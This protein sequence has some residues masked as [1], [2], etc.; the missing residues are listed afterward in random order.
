VPPGQHWCR[1]GFDQWACYDHHV[2]VAALG[3]A[4]G[5]RGSYNYRCPVP[6]HADH[7]KS[8]SLN[9]GAKGKWMVWHCHAGC[10]DADVREMLLK[11]GAVEQCLGNYGIDF[12]DAPRPGTPYRKTADPIVFAAAKRCSAMSALA[13]STLKNDALLRMCIQAISDGDGDLPGNPVRL[14]PT[15]QAAF[16]ALAKR[17][18]VERRYRY[19]LYEKWL[20]KQVD[21][22]QP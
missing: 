8:F 22:V 11:L 5:K 13:R 7:R 19:E 6:G 14:L 1:D 15:N 3:P 9:A 10:T 16:V 17:T 2:A 18:G 4:T 12:Q 20:G 21:Y